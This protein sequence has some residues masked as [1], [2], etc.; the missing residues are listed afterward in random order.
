MFQNKLGPLQYFKIVSSMVEVKTDQRQSIF[1]IDCSGNSKLQRFLL[2]FLKAS[3]SIAFHHS[4]NGKK[5]VRARLMGVPDKF[6]PQIRAYTY[7]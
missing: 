2:L 5:S 3:N 6:Q 1:V 4:V 7:D